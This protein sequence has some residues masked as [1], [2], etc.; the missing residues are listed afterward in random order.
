LSQEIIMGGPDEPK[1]PWRG[2]KHKRLLAILIILLVGASSFYMG[3]VLA[4]PAPTTNLVCEPGGCTTPNSCTD[5]IWLD[6]TTPVDTKNRASQVVGTAGQDA[7]A[8]IM[9]I[10]T[11]S[12]TLCFSPQTFTIGSTVKVLDGDILRGQSMQGTSFTAANNLNAN[13]FNVTGSNVAFYDLTVNGN[14]ANEASGTC[15][16]FYPTSNQNYALIQNVQV[17]QC[18]TDGIA[19]GVGPNTSTY[20]NVRIRASNINTNGVNNVHFGAYSDDSSLDSSL[21]AS[22]SSN[23]IFLAST[24]GITIGPANQIYQSCGDGIN[25]AS[26]SSYAIFGNFIN[27]NANAGIRLVSAAN[28]A[29]VSD[30]V[31]VGNSFSSGLPAGCAPCGSQCSPGIL[32]TDSNKGITIVGNFITGVTQ[33]YGI[34]MTGTSDYLTVEAN[35][36]QNNGIG[37]INPVGTHNYFCCDLGYAPAPRAITAGASPY[38]YTDTDG[39]RE[40]LLI[41]AQNGMTAMTCRTFVVSVKTNS[42][43]PVLNPVSN[44][45]CV[46]TWATSAPIFEVLPMAA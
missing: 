17:T 16:S 29:T 35:N 9:S 42:T 18:K 22:A 13:L 28:N 3:R 14:K 33:S 8:F 38:T 21:V 4:T 44:D 7:G 40:Q 5:N 31:I 45:A 26:S 20:K 2:F 24:S 12:E 36:L 46:L 32:V 25:V 19:V 15:I 6:G 30:N 27:N 23:S 39:Y 34:T 37:A 1:I 43:S 10:Q 41:T 11:T